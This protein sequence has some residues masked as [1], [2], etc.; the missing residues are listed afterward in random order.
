MPTFTREEKASSKH[1]N[2]FEVDKVSSSSSSTIETTKSRIPKFDWALSEDEEVVTAFVDHVRGKTIK[3]TEKEMA[4]IRNGVFYPGFFVGCVVGA[5]S[6]VAM[7]RV[8]I[9]LM[10]KLMK[11]DHDNLVK[12]STQISSLDHSRK[13]KPFKE[14]SMLKII[15]KI[16]SS[17]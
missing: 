14:G 12:H 10:N 8:P 5:G 13:L 4:I 9:Y 3:P 15:G 1:N 17:M 16:R 2:D 6:F 11:Y 7:R